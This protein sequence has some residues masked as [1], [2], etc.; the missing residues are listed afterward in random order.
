MITKLWNPDV[1]S[2]CESAG[3]LACRCLIGLL[4]S[5]LLFEP[6][7][8]SA[9]S[10]RQDKRDRKEK[11]KRRRSDIDAFSKQETTLEEEQAGTSEPQVKIGRLSK[12][13]YD[14]VIRSGRYI[15]G[16]GDIFVVVVDRNEEP[17]V[18]DILVGAA[19]KLVIPYV[20]AI[21]VAGLSLKDADGAIQ[22]AVRSRFQHLGISITLS[23][24]RTFS[25]NVV[26]EVRF[27]G[28]YEVHGV[29]QV[30]ELI[31]RAGGLLQE[32]EGRASLR[33]IE[34][35][36]IS[37]NGTIEKSGRKAD[38]AL[39]RLSGE[40][41]Y[42][43]FL[44]DGDQIL[45]PVLGDSISISG[46]VQRPG[47]YEYAP[48]DRVADL[49]RLGGGLVGNLTIATAERLR[50]PKNGKTEER[51][52]I[53]LGRALNGDPAAN[54]K[55]Q[56]GDKLYVAGAE[57]RVTV[58]GEVR[59]P[60]AYPI[61]DNLTLKELIRLAG[62]FTALAS[63]AQASL[64]RKV[65]YGNNNDEEDVVLNRLL[66]LPRSQ[67]TDEERALLTMK[68]QQVPGR[69]PVDFV[70]LF[71]R[72]DEKHNIHL[73][74]D[75]IVRVPRFSPSVLVN[76]FVLAPAAIPYDSTY[77]I[78]DYIARAGGF[79]DRARKT[80]VVVIQGSTGNAVKASKVQRISPGDAIYV[81]SKTPGQGWRI[82]REALLV[83]TQIAT[84]ILI[85][86][87]TRK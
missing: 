3:V 52:Q 73:K 44:L 39:W 13:A 86:Q 11:P 65:E 45:V 82:F 14:A 76:G 38:L 56:T 9:Q 7:L 77:I 51:I 28:A 50:L 41:D 15:L 64:I 22:A 68:T 81:P 43:P 25:V 62:G 63:L 87:N 26:G 42:N 69:L 74:G 30:S 48:D 58:E 29:E 49:V 8:L 32:P 55:L 21:Q 34:V 35:Q 71:E 24:L 59:F 2:G 72:G 40:I 12:A 16:P 5:V 85:I 57:Q 54:L 61:E 10:R 17:E 31:M 75:D 33:N 19:G 60:G 46:A 70:A 27:P 80:D 18:H 20:G 83:I 1:T 84:L 37:E 4:V 67:L 23:V 78:S 47:N 36:R 53:D 6:I 66:S 79:S